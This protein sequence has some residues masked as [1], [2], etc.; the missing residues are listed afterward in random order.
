MTGVV[1]RCLHRRHHNIFKT[2]EEHLT[3]ISATLTK[4]REH[5]L[6][7]KPSKCTWGK[8]EL[9]YLGLKVGHGKLA[10]SEQRVAAISGYHRPV[11]KRDMK[12][13]LG[14]VGYYRAFIPGLS[15]REG[16]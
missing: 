13:F 5:G 2:W 6:T 8:A 3:H 11:T 4:L 1:Y 15:A 14:T 16:L 9:E 10:V 7:V 12:A